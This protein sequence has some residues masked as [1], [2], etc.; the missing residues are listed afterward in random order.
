MRL[1]R[2]LCKRVQLAGSRILFDLV[3][4]R[5]CVKLGIPGTEPS[6]LLLRKLGHLNFDLLDVVHTVEDYQR[7]V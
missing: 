7:P 1:E 2:S 4:P 6:K 5:V 3:V